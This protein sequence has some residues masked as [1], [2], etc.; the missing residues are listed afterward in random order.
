MQKTYRI[1]RRPAGLFFVCLQCGHEIDVNG[2]PNSRIPRR[3]RRTL[4]A[5][6]MQKHQD[7][8]HR[9]L[10]DRIAPSS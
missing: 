2:F 7:Q 3:S 9:K 6:E 5:A 10:W 1:E 8:A 4:A